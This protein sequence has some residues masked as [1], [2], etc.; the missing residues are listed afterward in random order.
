M[1]ALTIYDADGARDISDIVALNRRD[2]E[3]EQKA[4]K[5]TR[6]SSRR[7]WNKLSRIERWKQGGPWLDPDTFAL[8]YQIQK[9]SGGSVLIARISD[10][11][12]GELDLSIGTSTTLE[13]C[14]HITWIV[15]DPTKR[16]EGIG[17]QLLKHALSIA[18]AQNCRFLTTT[19][20]NVEARR[21]FQAN[22]FQF[23]DYEATFTKKLTTQGKMLNDA[24]H[25]Q[26]FPLEWKPR[27]HTPLGFIPFLGINYPAEQIWTYLRY[28]NQL[29]TMLNSDLPRPH[30]WLLRHNEAEALTVDGRTIRIWVSKK[31]RDDSQ[32]LTKTLVAT[33]ALSTKNG[34]TELTVFAREN[35]FQ[36]LQENE[37]DLL[38]K[39]PVLMLRV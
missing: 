14:A 8:H 22:E 19:T 7:P 30:L 3:S 25:I 15:I 12:V 29:Y 11:I 32:F 18:R 38:Q 27:V 13:K 26:H 10:T 23:V 37:Y 34:V 33:E 16:R 2:W 24:T 39:R 21:F 35:Q 4:P 36:L 20:D 5:K 9:E 1:T 28:T 17:L 6:A 31:C